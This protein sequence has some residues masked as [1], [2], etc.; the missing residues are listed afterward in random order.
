VRLS[1]TLPGS[2]LRLSG[3]LSAVLLCA[4][5]C[6]GG[7]TP[8]PGPFGGEY[9]LDDG[10]RVL[11]SDEGDVTVQDGDRDLFALADAAH[12]T[13]RTFKLS[14]QTLLGMWEFSRLD[15]AATAFDRFEG[16][17]MTADGV[18][19]VLGSS[20]E[21][22]ARLEVSQLVA[23]QVTRVRLTVEGMGEVGSIAVPMRCDEAAT[24][25]G[26]GEQYNGTDQRGEAF[27]L[28]VSE[29]GIGRP[30][31]GDPL[32]PTGNR[33][34][35]YFPMP[36]FMDARGFGALVHTDRRALVDLCAADPSVA[37]IEVESGAPLEMVLYHGPTP[38]DVIRQLG[39]E[40]GRPKELPAWAYG[41]WVSA[42]GGRDKV[43]ARADK[44]IADDIPTTA[45][46]SQDWTG[47]RM[48]I[49]GGYGVQYRWVEDPVLYPDLG[50]MIAEL[51]GKG[52]KFLAYVNPFVMPGLEHFDEM[53]AAGLLVKRPSGALYD[54]LT[55]AGDGAHPDLTN[56]EAREYVK[57]F[58]RKMVEERGIDGWMADFGEWQPTNAGLFSGEDAF[59]YHNRYPVEWHRLSREVMDEL[60]PD[61]DYAVF[62]RSGF[63]GE[64][65]VAQIVWVGD[66]EADWSPTDGLP[67]VVPAMLNLG[68]AGIPF[69]THDIAGFSGGPSSKELYMRWTELGAFTP[70]MRTHDGNNKDTNWSW[71]SDAE[72]T[73]HF[74]RFVRI[75]EA[76]APELAALAKEAVVSS[77]P[78]VRHLMLAAPDDPGSRATSDAF[79]LGPDLLVAP[80]TTE[81]AASRSVYLPPGKWF[82][83][84]TGEEYTGGATVTVD[85]P[86]GS[87]PVFSRDKDRTD[88]RS[89]Q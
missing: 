22:K 82:H 53:E 51:H 30:D 47:P 33:H 39:D 5:G 49:G 64:Q 87:P 68:L 42:Q 78:I 57:S 28:F 12:P 62:T 66:Q 88:L 32:S 7:D 73:A 2:S 8:P 16:S 9:T 29:Q 10:T 61:G 84:W 76:L 48:N 89:I 65:A 74:R 83:V 31:G 56:P 79:L 1:F 55:P 35:T 67:T 17:S 26:F 20:G 54:F 4:P 6:D 21:A 13:A 59:G 15:E 23:G 77:M 25:Y 34:T 44:L 40:L 69:V 18:E 46:W 52:L 36:Y 24:Y 50:G 75:H 27:P 14:Q 70:I 60:R 58:L 71:D 86:L 43:L 41:L 80:V 85:A 19:I 72:T 38:A 63:T 45:I 11:V 81:G 3:A 37:W